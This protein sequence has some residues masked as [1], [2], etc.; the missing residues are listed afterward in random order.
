[1]PLFA[2]SLRLLP[3]LIFD[4]LLHAVLVELVVEHVFVRVLQ[5]RL[6]N[7]SLLH[8]LLRLHALLLIHNALLLFVPVFLLL[9]ANREVLHVLLVD[10]GLLVES[11]SLVGEVALLICVPRIVIKFWRSRQVCNR[12]TL[13]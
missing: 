7:A 1:M 5:L 9:L 13:P 8:L 2:H 3:L 12:L 10:V 4:L 6:V 11:S